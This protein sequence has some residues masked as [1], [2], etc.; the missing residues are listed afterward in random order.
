MAV[1]PH[2]K[3]IE[4]AIIADHEATIAEAQRRADE[5]DDPW[6]RK[7]HQ[8]RADRLRAMRYPWEQSAA[9]A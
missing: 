9:S 4:D 6:Y 5:A 8:D 3:A 2:I 1:D 7:W